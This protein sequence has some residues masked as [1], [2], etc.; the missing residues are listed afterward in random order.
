M[1]DAVVVGS[2][3]NGLAAALTLAMAGVRVTVLEAADTVGGGTRSV[4]ATVPGAVH[5]ECSGFHPFAVDNRFARCVDL[6]RYG[7]TWAWPQVQYAH[8]L[9]GGQGA[10]VYRSVEDTAADLGRDGPSYQ[11]MFGP[12]TRRFGDI[13]DEFLQPIVHVPRHPVSLAR[14][15]LYA[16]LP[17]T[18]LG[19]RFETETAR[20]LWGGLAAHAFRPLGSP[21]SSAIGVALGA[22]AHR[23]G[24]PVA[25]GGSASITRAMAM[26]LT[27]HGGQ[28]ETGARVRD[29]AE[30]AGYDLAFLDTS[31]GAAAD[32]LQP[33]QSPRV[34]R[35][36]RGYRHGPSAFQV[37]F[38]V[39]EGIPWAYEPARRAGTVHVG[40]TMA[41]MAAAEA[42]CTEGRMPERPF[43]L[44]GQQYLADPGRSVGEVHPVDC[45]AHVPAGFT[46]DA[47]E[48]IIGQIERFAP[49]FRKRIVE[50]TVR[51]TGRLAI[52]NAN[53]V[54]GDIVGGANTPRQL[55]F[56]PRMTPWPYDAG[57]PETYLCSASTPPGAGAHG[58]AGYL[59]A[60]R[61]LRRLGLGTAN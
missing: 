7:L 8:P 13:A 52:D 21:L 38:A 49:G 42:E 51:S 24:W 29:A 9:D 5:D 12:L 43:V 33:L 61:G 14:F 20:A 39:S 2:G 18:V 60:R 57:V 44:L 28:V 36:Y 37:A 4:E 26:A 46:G 3:P 34:Q 55:V 32:I 10:A 27:D 11:R 47:T 6:T 48:A 45:Y 56:R 54:G 30:L 58:M 59:A 53:L 50:M 23:F 17:A 40:G 25:V 22:A 35:A 16:I 19:R 15:G 41:E 1:T 31:P